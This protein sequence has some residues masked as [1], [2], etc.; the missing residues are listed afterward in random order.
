[1]SP[2]VYVGCSD[3][4]VALRLGAGTT[5]SV[6]WRGRNFWA[7][8]PIVAGGLVWTVD[9]DA[10]SLNALDPTSGQE[11]FRQSLGAAAHFTTPAA[12]DGRL[13]VAAATTIVAFT[14]SP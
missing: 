3:G 5:F 1:M 12:G 7:E 10:A 4:L 2:F 6:A 13:Y 9:R 8:P 11:R 14:G